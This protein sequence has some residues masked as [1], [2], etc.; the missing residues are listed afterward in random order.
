MRGFNRAAAGF[1]TNRLKCHMVV[2]SWI[3]F[4]SN[5]SLNV[6]KKH[7]IEIGSN[8]SKMLVLTCI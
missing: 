3:P 1:R 8:E 4:E 2:L 6:D 7:I 5:V